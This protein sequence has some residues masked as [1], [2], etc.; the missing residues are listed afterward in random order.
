MELIMAQIN[1]LDIVEG[2][3]AAQDKNKI[4]I[5]LLNP[6]KSRTSVQAE[7]DSDEWAIFFTQFNEDDVTNFS[8]KRQKQLTGDK[9]RQEKIKQEQKS[10]N[11][12]MQQLFQAK[13]EAFEIET[14]QASENREMRAKVRRS[15]SLTEV[16]ATTAALIMME[17]K[18]GESANPE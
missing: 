6:D 18:N 13:L 2:I 11:T 14:V 15:K 3:W 9:K 7:R 16:Y 8:E 4:A 12:Q 17:M 10:V 5:L 1:G